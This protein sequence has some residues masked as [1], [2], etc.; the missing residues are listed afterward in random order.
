MSFREA[1]RTKAMNAGLPVVE[2]FSYL[3]GKQG[4][5]EVLPLEKE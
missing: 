1:D 2:A 3:G 4:Y 5:E